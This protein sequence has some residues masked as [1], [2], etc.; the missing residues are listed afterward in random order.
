MSILDRN[1][2]SNDELGK[3][4][5]TEFIGVTMGGLAPLNMFLCIQI[6]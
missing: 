1:L 6:F 4:L 3:R 2:S 5:R